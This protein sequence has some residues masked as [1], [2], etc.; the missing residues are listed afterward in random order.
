MRWC[1][2]GGMEH[3]RTLKEP[4]QAIPTFAQ[5]IELLM[6]VNE[7]PEAPPVWLIRIHMILTA[8]EPTRKV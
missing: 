3:V 2:E 4:R 5:T 1:G 6:K 8:R 7:Y